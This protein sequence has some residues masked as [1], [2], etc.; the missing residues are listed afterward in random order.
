MIF[1]VDAIFMIIKDITS[2]IVKITF[3][4]TAHP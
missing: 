3:G 1:V 2:I 4:A